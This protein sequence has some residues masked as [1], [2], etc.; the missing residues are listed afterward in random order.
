MSLNEFL[1]QSMTTP[2][3]KEDPRMIEAETTYAH[4]FAHLFARL[5]TLHAIPGLKDADISKHTAKP[6]LIRTTSTTA[7]LKHAVKN[8]TRQA[9][10]RQRRLESKL[11][12]LDL[13]S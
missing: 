12:S 5:N 3:S 1:L 2:V 9:R 7:D 13:S 11:A 10:R 8:A 4:L 6:T